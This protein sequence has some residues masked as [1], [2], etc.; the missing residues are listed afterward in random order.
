MRKKTVNDL[1]PFL[2]WKKKGEMNQVMLLENSANHDHSKNSKLKNVEYSVVGA[3][4]RH[5]KEYTFT[6]LCI[7]M[8]G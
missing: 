7:F 4:P 1:F 5:S 6:L 2:C 3:F 8:F